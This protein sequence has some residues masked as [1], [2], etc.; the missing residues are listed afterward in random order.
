MSDD[1]TELIRAHLDG[2]LTDEQRRA[3][4]DWLRQ[5]AANVDLFVAECRFHS[6][7]LDAYGGTLRTAESPL[8]VVAHQ[9]LLADD[10][11][12]GL[13]STGIVISDLSTSHTPSSSFGSFAFSYGIAAVLVSIGL[14]IGW[15]CHI[16]VHQQV[17]NDV[18]QPGALPVHLGPE[19]TFVGRVTGLVDCRWADAKTEA[20]AGAHVPLGRRYTLASGLMEISYDSGAKVILEGPCTY[21]V[22]TEASGYLT[23]GKLTAKIKK[24]SELG[25]RNGE[26][27][28][29][30]GSESRIPNSGFFAVRTPT[31]IVTDLGTEFGVEVEKSGVT[32]SRVFRGSVKLQAASANGDTRGPGRVLHANDS[33]RVERVSTGQNGGDSR[34]VLET[35]AK[36]VDFVRKM[37]RQTIR[38]FD[39]VD[40]I[41]GGNGFSGRRNRGVDP[42]NGHPIEKPILQSPIAGDG[43]YHRSKELPFVDGVFIPSGR[44]Q[45]DS[46]GHVAELP[47]TTLTAAGGIWTGKDR[48]GLTSNPAVLGAVDYSSAGHTVLHLHANQGITFDLAAIRR[49][50]PNCKILRFRAVTGNSEPMSPATATYSADLWVL[51]DGQVRYQRREIGGLSG[52]SAASVPISNKDRFLTLV[53]TDAGNGIEAD[54]I[55]F[56]DPRLE[57]VATES[58][59]GSKSRQP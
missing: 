32:R 54:W 52:P 8:G 29:S 16:S 58:S 11:R 47:K 40:A 49:A 43:Q 53:S 51:V 24:N 56:G 37:P 9:P 30:N 20:L 13:P 45:V 18:P 25:I 3:L 22:E 55:V 5:D 33:A 39:L 4:V 19:R 6:E 12:S 44:T 36:P 42:T 17:V 2:E 7:L 15:V 1:P 23:V 41:A 35:S 21:Q 59:D 46:A 26:K 27:R 50:N 31:A 14:L 48:T 10:G 57:F 34:V 38:A 28:A